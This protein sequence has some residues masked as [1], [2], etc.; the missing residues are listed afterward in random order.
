[1]IIHKPFTEY[2]REK[3]LEP[4]GMTRST[5]DGERISKDDNRAF[6]YNKMIER[7][8]EEIPSLAAGG[9]HASIDD[10]ARFLQFQ[11]NNGRINGVSLIDERVLTQMRTIPFPMKRLP[12]ISFCRSSNSSPEKRSPVYQS[13]S[14]GTCRQGRLILRMFQR[15]LWEDTME[16][17][18]TWCSW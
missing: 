8:P 14:A 13:G 18:M 16:Q 9:M 10:M 4:L 17:T 1:M 6:G 11:L 7:V 12:K 3:V 2:V 15:V 5:Y